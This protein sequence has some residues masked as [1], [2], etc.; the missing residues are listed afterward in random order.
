[1]QPRVTT[2]FLALSAATYFGTLTDPRAAEL[3]SWVP[4]AV[5]AAW[6]ALAVGTTAAGVGEPPLQA[7]GCGQSRFRCSG[8]WCEAEEGVEQGVVVFGGADGGGDVVVAGLADEP[9]AEVTEGD[10]DA[11]A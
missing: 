5:A 4:A 2:F 10:Q 8:G 6:A 1:M 3:P 7:Q 11:G 9:H